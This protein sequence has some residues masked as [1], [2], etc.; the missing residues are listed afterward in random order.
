MMVETKDDDGTHVGGGGSGGTI[1]RE[2]DV[3]GRDGGGL[4]GSGGGETDGSSLRLRNDGGGGG[5][6]GGRDGFK[7]GGAVTRGQRQPAMQ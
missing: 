4:G 3:R 6:G 7:V 5:S 1:G 2:S